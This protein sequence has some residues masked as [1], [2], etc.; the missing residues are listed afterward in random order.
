MPYLVRLRTSSAKGWEVKFDLTRDELE[1]RIL[2]PYRAGTTIVVGGRSIEP[3]D[4]KRIEVIE[5]PHSSAEFNQ[6]TKVSPVIAFVAGHI[7][8]GELKT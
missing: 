3:A 2:G 5:T 1:A 8:S 7:T 6:L 4:I